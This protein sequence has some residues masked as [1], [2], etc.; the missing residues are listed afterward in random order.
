MDPLKSQSESPLRW[1]S[2]HCGQ[3]INGLHPIAPRNSREK[4]ASYPS[5]EVLSPLSCEAAKNPPTAS[6]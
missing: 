6:W 5:K 2:W 3:N 1:L 4:F